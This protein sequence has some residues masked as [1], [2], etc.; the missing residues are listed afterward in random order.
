MISE[1]FEFFKYKYYNSDKVMY[2]FKE[3]VFKLEDVGSQT[4]KYFLFLSCCAISK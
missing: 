2:L 3:S 1:Y 4:W